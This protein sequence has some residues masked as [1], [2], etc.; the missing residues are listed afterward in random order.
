MLTTLLI[1]TIAFL[2]LT[3][4]SILQSNLSW[5]HISDSRFWSL[6]ILDTP[7]AATLFVTLVG[8]LLVR[9]QFA[10]SVLPRIN[11][12]SDFKSKPSILR[13]SDPSEIWY[14]EIRNTGLGAAIIDRIEYFLDIAN[15]KD[16]KHSYKFDSLILKLNQMDLVRYTDYYMFKMSSGFSLA[17]KDECLVLEIKT[18]HLAKFDRLTM[19]VYFE[20]QL[21]DKYCREISLLAKAN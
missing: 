20:G 8:G 9:H 11:Y 3:I 1:S 12:V 16:V 6:K 2:I 13:T 18:E 19:I 7:S 21:G 14:V 10:I 15:D 5:F 17:P 4:Y